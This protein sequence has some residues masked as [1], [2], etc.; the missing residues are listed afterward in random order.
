LAFDQSGSFYGTTFG[1]GAN[2]LGS[3]FKLTPG[4]GG[5]SYTSLY[6]FSDQYVAAYPISNVIFD[7]SGNLYGTTSS[8]GAPYDCQ[9]SCGVVWEITP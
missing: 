5:W 3:V 8:G 4:A 1:D 6:D 2:D 7:T 9:E